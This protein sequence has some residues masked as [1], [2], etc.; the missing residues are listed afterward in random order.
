MVEKTT[1]KFDMTYYFALLEIYAAV[2][3][4]SDEKY[5][6]IEECYSIVS[7]L[8]KSF[9]DIVGKVFVSKTIEVLTK[10]KA[11]ANSDD[12]MQIVL[13]YS[14]YTLLLALSTYGH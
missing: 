11:T 12:K 6:D 13:D 5:D 3:E 4:L 1:S 7:H 2:R 8:V 9:E 10:I 14:A